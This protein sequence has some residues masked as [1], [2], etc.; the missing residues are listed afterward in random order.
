MPLAK[1]TPSI[2]PINICVVETG[3]PRPEQITTVAAVD[4]CAAKPLEG[5]NSVIFEPTVAITLYPKV[6]SPATTPD[7]P[8]ITIQNGKWLLITNWPL[9]FIKLKIVAIGP[10]ALAVS[11]DPWANAIAQAVNT[12]NTPKDCSTFSK[13]LCDFCDF[14]RNLTS[15]IFPKNDANKL[16]ITLYRYMLLLFKSNPSGFKPFAK[17]T[18]IKIM[19]TKNI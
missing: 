17:V 11:F 13:G 2:A 14:F 6:A 10:M 8:K 15:H 5:V 1:P 19:L 16:K 3:M 12:I 18:Q 9:F 4:N 7:V